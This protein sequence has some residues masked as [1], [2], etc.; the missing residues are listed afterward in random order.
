MAVRK[1][2]NRYWQ[3]DF[4]INGVRY[5]E[6]SPMNTKAGAEAYEA[7]LRQRLA[8]GE[9]IQMKSPVIEKIDFKTFADEWMKTTVKTTNKPSE[10]RTKISIL[11]NHLLP[12]FGVVLLKG[13]TPLLIEQYKT[14]KI[15]QGLTAKTVN[16]HLTILKRCLR[17][18]LEWGRLESMPKTALLKTTSQRLDFLSPSESKQLIQGY[19]EPM[20]RE[21]LLL[22]LRTGL[23]LGELCALDW[24]DIDFQNKQL[25]VNRS[26]VR[27]IVGTPK[28]GKPRYIP[29][30][31]EVC[32]AIYERRQRK[33]FV[34]HRGNGEPLTD[35]MASNAI[36]RACKQ[37]GVRCIGWHTLRH[38]FASRLVSEGVALNVVQV[39]LGHSTIAMTMRYAHLAPSATRVAIDVLEQAE[40]RVMATE[41]LPRVYME[42]LLTGIHC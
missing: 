22:A 36:Q 19:H 32:K 38:T 31:D 33:G 40:N 27:G 14:L 6:S 41:C 13:I 1:P 24:Q 3:V 8:R 21:M 11:K 18:A 37:S 12:F 16:N 2:K 39:L 17:V 15:K 35:R 5:R 10:V 29:L 20:W 34:F 9:D 7:T 26:I 23:R 25:A 30:T 42:T 4:Q 28:S